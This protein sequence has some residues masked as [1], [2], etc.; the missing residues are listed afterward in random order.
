[1]RPVSVMPVPTSFHSIS[2]CCVGVA[3][4]ALAHTLDRRAYDIPATLA[5]DI[6]AFCNVS[7]CLIPESPLNPQTPGRASW[8][9]VVC[10]CPSSV[11]I[12]FPHFS[13]V[14]ASLLQAMV[15]GTQS[16]VGLRVM[17]GY[18]E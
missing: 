12:I 7:K 8:S 14:I 15:T 18:R 1:M 10:L 9:N 2:S 4:Q 13:I 6:D 17:E 16:G 11:S 5:S 3:L